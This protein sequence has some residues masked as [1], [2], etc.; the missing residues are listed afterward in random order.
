MPDS[1][2]EDIFELLHTANQLEETGKNRIE[3]ATKVGGKLPCNAV[4]CRAW[5]AVQVISLNFFL[6]VAAWYQPTTI[7]NNNHHQIVL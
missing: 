3:A 1:M 7:N 6:A 5:S 2:I 4:P